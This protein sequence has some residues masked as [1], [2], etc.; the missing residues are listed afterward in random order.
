MNASLLSLEFAVIVTGLVLLLLDLWTDPEKKRQLGYIGAAALGGVLLWSLRIDASTPQEAFLGAYVMDPLALYFKRFFLVAG[1][2]VL[3]MAVDF[4]DG[5][6]AGI[7]EFYSLCLLAL[8]GMMFAASANNFIMLFVSIELITVVFYILTSFLRSKTTSLEAG[9][10]YLILGAL[11]SALMVYGIALVF[12]VTG[13]MQ[14]GDLAAKASA[15]AN[16]KLFLV[17]LMLVISGLA[18]KIAA[19][20]LHVWAPDVYQ[21]SPAPA[22]AF[23]AVGSKAAGFALLL[24]LLFGGLPAGLVGQWSGALAGMAAITI[25]YGSLCAIPQ[26]SLKRLMGYS[27]IANGGFMLLGIAAISQAGSAA[28]I[29]Y[30]TG[31][32]FTVLAAFMTISIVT[33]HLESDDI[34]AVAGL[35]RKSPF[36]AAALALSM[37]SLAGVPPL[38]G[39]FGKF[40]LIKSVLEN[41]AAHYWLVAVAAIGVVIS[42]YYYF[43]VVRAIYWSD[44]D[45]SSPGPVC[46][47]PMRIALAACM[48]GMLYFGLFPS[49]GLALATEASGILK[50]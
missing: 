6:A 29:Y 20:P 5:I 4:A 37:V 34:S 18:F 8:A 33:R 26:R 16:S 50:F 13:A 47:T 44:A 45:E 42:L 12:G 1:I 30:L 49:A 38:A 14:F 36:L 31:Y 35:G 40:L 15:H 25:L 2:A 41:G 24:R 27:S 7:G 28:V 32:L 46:P 17:G 22:T 19:F 3:I 39:F 48:V 10:K 43:G 23:L 11:S 9:I 21:G